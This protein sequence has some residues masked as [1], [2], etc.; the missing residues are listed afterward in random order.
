[1]KTDRLPLRK[2]H[3][4]LSFKISDFIKKKLLKRHVYYSQLRETREEPGNQSG[5]VVLS[6][7]LFRNFFHPKFQWVQGN[8]KAV[9]HHG[10]SVNSQIPTVPTDLTAGRRPF[11]FLSENSRHFLSRQTFLSL[12][13]RSGCLSFLFFT[14]LQSM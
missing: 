12:S 3:V 4:Y 2:Q 13:K 1:M 7:L 5:N 10:N 14:F 6:G 8:D 11:H 9:N